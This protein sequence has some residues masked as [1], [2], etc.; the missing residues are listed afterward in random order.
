MTINQATSTRGEQMLALRRA[1]MA[2]SPP[3]LR[4]AFRPFFFLGP[5]WAVAALT[6][7]L[8]T[9]AGEIVLP[10]V[11]DPLAWHRHEMLFGFVGAVIAGFLLTR[12][13]ER[14]VGKECVSTC[15][16]RWSPSR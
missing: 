2:A 5:L 8:L 9:L 15:R 16:S 13:E 12:S 4:G 7:W 1:R 10:T 6:L 14:R 11:L 3:I